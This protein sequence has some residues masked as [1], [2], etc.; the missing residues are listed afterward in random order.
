VQLFDTQFK[1]IQ[2][3]G[4]IK[5]IKSKGFVN[6]DHSGKPISMMGV[7]WDVTETAEAT[8]KLGKSEQLFRQIVETSQDGIWLH[9]GTNKTIFV[10]PR[11]TQIFGYTAEEMPYLNINDLIDPAFHNLVKEKTESRRKG[12]ADTYEL[13]CIR[14]TGQKIWI[15]VSASPILDKEGMYSGS[16]AML[17][18]ISERK[19][20][21][22][23][24]EKITQD[25]IQRNK[26]MEQFSY[27]VS[28]NLRAPLANI[29][30]CA[31]LIKNDI[32][33]QEE[34]N[35]IIDGIVCSAYKLDEVIKDLNQ[36]LQ[37]KNPLIEKREKV[38]LHEIVKEIK[39]SIYNVMASH[40]VTLKTDFK[41]IED[42]NS[43]RRYIYSIF[44][45]LIQNS[46]KYQ[47]PKVNPVIEIKSKQIE[48]GIKITFK[49]NGSGI[50]LQKEAHN[51][52]G[53]YKRFHQDI[54]GKGIGLFMVKTQVETIGGSIDINS[55]PNLGTEFTI[56]LPV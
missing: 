21:E 17:S 48:K 37:I 36:I 45:N 44:Y 10:N 31:E 24:K 20:E 47:N 49:D 7:N 16:L 43:V 22:L 3:T 53:L 18:D 55:E 26:N 56:E 6:Y 12:N 8:E 27:I 15:Q 38:N 25:L 46:I 42:L 41:D 40:K 51:I 35:K 19:K 39:Q 13:L 50:D 34:L 5:T 9:D 33:E 28:H 54:E 52:F 11:F 14:K 29:M 4:D 32:L 1:I 30:G 23:E 2:K